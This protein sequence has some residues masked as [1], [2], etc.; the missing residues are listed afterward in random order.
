MS[1]E[2]KKQEVIRAFSD[3]HPTFEKR[4]LL[5]K[6]SILEK[7]VMELDNESIQKVLQKVHNEVLVQCLYGFHQEAR[8]KILDNFSGFLD[9]YLR[10]E[11]V[12]FMEVLRDLGWRKIKE[13]DIL[14]AVLKMTAAIDACTI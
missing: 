8:E 13:A 6:L 12:V 10:M 11:D 5:K 3:I 2:Q 4:E 1:I 7:K 9:D 14:T